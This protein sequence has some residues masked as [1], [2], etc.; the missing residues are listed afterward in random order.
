[1][2]FKNVRCLKLRAGPFW[3]VFLFCC[4]FLAMSLLADTANL[5]CLV[6]FLFPRLFVPFSV[7]SSLVGTAWLHKLK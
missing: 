1:M 7:Y 5:A 4:Y 3:I 6:L 2:D